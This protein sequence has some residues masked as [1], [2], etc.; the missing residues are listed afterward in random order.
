M[1]KWSK[2]KALVL[3]TARKMEEKGLV[4]GTSGNVSLRLL[5]EGG[6]E[7]LAITPTSRYY[8]LL[9]PDDIQVI[10]FEAKPVEGSLPPSSESMMHIAIYRARKDIHAVI[11]THSV[12]GSAMAV[13]QLE[14]PPILDDQVQLTG[15]EIKLARYAPS[16]SDDLVRNVLEALEDRNAALLSHHG[17]VGVGRSI[18]DA[19][20]VC[21]TIE[22][23]AQ[24]YYLC[25]TLGKV[26]LLSEEAIQAGKAFFC[27]RQ[28]G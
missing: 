23:A 14:I 11:H 7:L 3:D 8:D 10:D 15:G 24:A 9:T 13:A 22:K 17:V 6:R 2:E 5:P 20:T 26:H 27:Q 28:Q 21:E 19:L 18:R 25:L 16:G 4:A 1:S 12:Y